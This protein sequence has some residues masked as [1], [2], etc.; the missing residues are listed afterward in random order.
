MNSLRALLLVL[1]VAGVS[2][3]ASAEEH[4][5]VTGAMAIA[6]YN[7]RMDLILGTDGLLDD[8]YRTM[9]QGSKA[10][11]AKYGALIDAKNAEY[12]QKNPESHGALFGSPTEREEFYRRWTTAIKA[13]EADQS[14]ENAVYRDAFR[15]AIAADPNAKTRRRVAEI[16]AKF[17]EESHLPCY[18]GR[19]RGFEG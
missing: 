12:T 3:V 8:A 10:V 15:R 1:G 9:E 7:S 14:R 6:G 5:M 16:E 17:D 4:C 11:E 19:Y 2:Q 13:L 18:W